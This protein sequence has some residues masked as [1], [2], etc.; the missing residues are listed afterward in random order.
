[1]R[2]KEEPN[3]CDVCI[4]PLQTGSHS[5]WWL[6]GVLVRYLQNFLRF[7][8]SSNICKRMF[9]LTLIRS[10][11]DLPATDRLGTAYGPLLWSRAFW[12]IVYN[13]FM[14]TFKFELIWYDL[15]ILQANSPEV[16]VHVLS[17]NNC[18]DDFFAEVK[19]EVTVLFEKDNFV[20]MHILKTLFR[21]TFW[22]RQNL[23]LEHQPVSIKDGFCDHL[24][25]RVLL[26]LR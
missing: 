5:L 12:H 10:T 4:G 18:C 6:V 24:P 22:Q 3:L 11:Q 16:A 2:Q 20:L 7:W 8:L 25:R 13:L 9:F 14:V 15:M 19:T 26:T 1:M 23:H 21:C 17:V